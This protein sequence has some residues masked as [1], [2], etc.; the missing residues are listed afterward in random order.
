MTNSFGFLA[1]DDPG[2]PE[3]ERTGPLPRVWAQCV[4][5]AFRPRCG[6]PRNGTDRPCRAL[7]LLPG[8]APPS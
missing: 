1:D 8:D 4:R 3:H 6:R 7:V 2:V 5:N